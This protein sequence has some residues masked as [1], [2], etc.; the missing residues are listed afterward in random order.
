MAAQF[1]D[2]NVK[3]EEDR[4]G[5]PEFYQTRDSVACTLKTDIF[6]ATS[7]NSENVTNVNMPTK[8]IRV[9]SEVLMK[10]EITSEEENEFQKEVLD[11]PSFHK[12]STEEVHPEDC[13]TLDSLLVVIKTEPEEVS[14]SVKSGD[15]HVLKG[16]SDVEAPLCKGTQHHGHENSSCNCNC[17]HVPGFSAIKMELDQQKIKCESI[18]VKRCMAQ[19]LEDIPYQP[20][21]CK[22]GPDIPLTAHYSGRDQQTCTQVWSVLPVDC[23]HTPELWADNENF[24]TNDPSQT[25]GQ[26]SSDDG[27]T[28]FTGEQ[29]LHK[30]SGG[31]CSPVPSQQ[32]NKHSGP[33]SYSCSECGRTFSTSSSL[34]RHIRIHKRERL[35]QCSQCDKTF[36]QSKSFK[37]HQ[38]T[39]TGEKPYKCTQCGKSFTR[40]DVLQIHQRIHTGEKPYLCSQCGKSFTRLD[41]YQNHHRTH[42]GEKPY[43]CSQC[44]KMFTRLD[45]YQNHQ[46]T[47]TGEKPYLCTSCGKCFLNLSNLR[48]HQRT[49]TE[50]R[51]Y[52]CSW[53]GKTF[54][55]SGHLTKHKKMHNLKKV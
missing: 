15:Q 2:S 16:N 49:H 45:V 7:E 29:T 3:A 50:E 26:S 22:P 32:H 21:L 5:C 18:K 37:L 51:P 48:N 34:H 28:W 9:G 14:L 41:V 27:N 36:T 1:Q 55:Q 17:K 54:I 4:T 42:T 40:T 53:C 30:R 31:K 24:S 12:A 38:R 44:A 47:H 39:H 35:F 46:R 25:P 33:K 13:Q 52:H 19:A 8:V 11:V 10:A 20:L 43:Q 6:V 23:K